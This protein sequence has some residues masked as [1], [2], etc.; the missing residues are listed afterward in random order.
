MRD[1]GIRARIRSVG[2]VCVRLCGDL[3]EKGDVRRHPKG[4][5]C[6]IAKAAKPRMI[7]PEKERILTPKA[8]ALR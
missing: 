5:R 2:C 7:I 3:H 1:N 8:H 4:S 6:D